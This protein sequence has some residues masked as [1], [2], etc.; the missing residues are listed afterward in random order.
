MIDEWNLVPQIWDKVRNECD[1]TS[2]KGL[3]ILTCSTKL[4][5]EKKREKIKHS[6]AG[7]VGKIYMKPMS[8]FE[9]NDSTGMA[10]LT[11]MFNNTQ[12]DNV[13]KKTSVEDLAN[14]IIRGGWPAN[15]NIPKKHHGV[16]PQSYVDAILDS[17]MNDDKERDKVKIS[18]LL[19][20]LARNESTIVSNTLF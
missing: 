2:D 8:L 6:G 13:N 4:T 14:F 15:L 20:S 17:D 7:R 11:K 9:S 5:D 16:I 19:K 3:Y 1:K 12:K 10:S 18:L